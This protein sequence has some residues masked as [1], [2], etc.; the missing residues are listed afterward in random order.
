MF[1]LVFLDPSLSNNT[2]QSQLH[3]LAGGEWCSV[4]GGADN[5][6]VCVANG[7]RS[8]DVLACPPVVVHNLG[9][10]ADVEW[11]W[12]RVSVGECHE[13]G[14]STGIAQVLQGIL[15]SI[16]R[17]EGEDVAVGDVVGGG[18]GVHETFTEIGSELGAKVANVVSNRVKDGDLDWSSDLNWGGGC[19]CNC[20][21]SGESEFHCWRWL[22]EVVVD[23]MRISE[24]AP[25]WALF[26]LVVCASVNFFCSQWGFMQR[27]LFSR[28]SCR[29]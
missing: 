29:I 18:G 26:I 11:N 19:N 2:D 7:A 6:R 13:V 15:V 14:C 27:Y 22:F 12:V 16:F 20:C 24:K 28:F 17:G 4:V 9:I 21:K 3:L 25:K 1:T 10:V 5:F 8:V 23:V